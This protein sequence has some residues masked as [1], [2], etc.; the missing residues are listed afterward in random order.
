MNPI[1]VLN[2]FQSK[3]HDYLVNLLRLQ[4]PIEYGILFVVHPI[5]MYAVSINLF[6]LDHPKL[7]ISPHFILVIWGEVSFYFLL[8]VTACH[9]LSFRFK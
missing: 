5:P 2:E 3:F 7:N 1:L 9:E 4:V 6:S 8:F